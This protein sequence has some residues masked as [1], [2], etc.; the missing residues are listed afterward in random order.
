MATYRGL[1][2][3]DSALFVLLAIS[4][5]REGVADGERHRIS[6]AVIALI[7]FGAKT[8]FELTSGATVFVDSAANHMTPL[9]WVH[10]VGAVCGI[11]SA[12]KLPTAHNT[13]TSS[14]TTSQSALKLERSAGL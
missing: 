2:G 14:V 7:G 12:M 11:L 5:L 10:V 8:L 13:A 1:S 4:I 9:P 6:V 3:I